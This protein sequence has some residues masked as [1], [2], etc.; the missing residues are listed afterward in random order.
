MRHGL[1]DDLGELAAARI[2]RR[3]VAAGAV[4]AALL[5]AAAL[6]HAALLKQSL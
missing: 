1:H 6:A 5:L 4:I 3:A 2:G